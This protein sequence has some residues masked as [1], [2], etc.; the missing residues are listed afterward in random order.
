MYTY[1]V[2]Y[3]CGHTGMKTCWAC[4]YYV[5]KIAYYAWSNAPEFYLIC[6]VTMYLNHYALQIKIFFPT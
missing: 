2:T 1:T 3:M 4:V 6:S 5:F